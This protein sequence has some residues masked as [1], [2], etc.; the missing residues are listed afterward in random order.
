VRLGERIYVNVVSQ[1]VKEFSGGLQEWR[2]KMEDVKALAQDAERIWKAPDAQLEDRSEVIAAI[3][4]AR[5][6]LNG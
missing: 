2:D 1:L 4:S 3:N 6:Q 5:E